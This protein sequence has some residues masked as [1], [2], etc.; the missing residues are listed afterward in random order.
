MHLLNCLDFKGHPNPQ[1]SSTAEHIITTIFSHSEV[2]LSLNTKP[3][4]RW[5][6]CLT[7]KHGGTFRWKSGMWSILDAC[8]L[9]LSQ[10]QMAIL[11]SITADAWYYCL[12][13]KSGHHLKNNFFGGYLTLKKKSY[14][15]S[16]T[17][18]FVSEIAVVTFALFTFW[19]NSSDIKVLKFFRQPFFRNTSGLSVGQVPGEH[20][21]CTYLG[22]GGTYCLT[23]IIFPSTSN[24]IGFGGALHYDYLCCSHSPDE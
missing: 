14:L 19:L 15:E 13:M 17:N 20:R 6:W 7:I 2:N 5:F 4:K 24:M 12:K 23:E 9:H 21:N 1:I 22:K 16:F 3:L 10:L 18:R 11:W 8:M